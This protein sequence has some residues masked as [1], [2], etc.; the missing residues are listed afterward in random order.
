MQQQQKQQQQ[1]GTGGAGNVNNGDD[2]GCSA[3]VA[4]PA[5]GMKDPN[6]PGMSTLLT[7]TSSGVTCE[8]TAGTDLAERFM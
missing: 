2:G 3:A 7:S 8:A 4:D 1:P 5:P 6:A